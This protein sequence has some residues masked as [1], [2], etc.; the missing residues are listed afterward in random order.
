MRYLLDEWHGTPEWA[1]RLADEKCGGRKEKKR[2]TV[3]IGEKYKVSWTFNPD[4]EPEIMIVTEANKNW[5][6]TVMNDPENDTL[7]FEKIEEE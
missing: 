2:T 4:E 1:D 6:E 3:E 7:E 5:F